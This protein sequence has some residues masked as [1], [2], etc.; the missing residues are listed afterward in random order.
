[1]FNIAQKIWRFKNIF[2]LRWEP[3]LLN[4]IKKQKKSSKELDDLLRI[5][6]KNF[7]QSKTEI[8]FVAGLFLIFALLSH[9]Q[10]II[11]AL[12]KNESIISTTLNYYPFKGSLFLQSIDAHYSNLISV[13][14]G[15]GA[16]L[17][18]LAFFIAQELTKEGGPYKGIILLRRS[19]FFTLLVAEILSFLLFIWG[20]VNIFAALPIIII[21]IFTIISL[22][23]TIKL[24]TN[25]VGMKK[26]EDELLSKIIIGGFLKVLDKEITKRIATNTLI[27]KIKQHDDIIELNPFSPI[28]KEL[29]LP[30]KTKTVGTIIDIRLRKLKKLI[31]LIG[32]KQVTDNSLIDQEVET[33]KKNEYMDRLCQ[34]TPMP[35]SHTDFYSGN[36]FWIKK[37]ILDN[38]ITKERIERMARDIFVI[39]KED[40]IETEARDELVKLKIRSIEAIKSLRNEELED[41]VA[42]YIKLVDNFYSMILLYGGGFSREQAEKERTNFIEK[43]KPMDWLSSDIREILEVSIKSNRF[44]MIKTVAYL[45]FIFMRKAVDNKDHLVFQEFLYFSQILY[46]RGYEMQKNG[47]LRTSALVLDRTWRYLKEFC[48]YYLEQKLD[49]GEDYPVEDFKDFSIYL[50]KIFQYLLKAAL[51][52]QDLNNFKKFLL[53]V[54]GLFKNLNN[55]YYR[56]NREKGQEVFDFIDSKRSEM[57]FGLSSWILY[58]Y[59]SN[60]ENTRIKE[61]FNEIKSVLPQDIV[62]FTDIFLNVHNFKVE[63]FWG[64]DHWESSLYEEG[65]VH[66]IQIIEKTERLYVIHALNLI[67]S[68][69]QKELDQIKLPHNRDMEFLADG[70]RDLMKTIKNI[71]ENPESWNDLLDQNAISKTDS[72]RELLKKAKEDQEEDDLEKKRSTGIDGNKIKDFKEKFIKNYKDSHPIKELIRKFGIYEDKIKFKYTGSVKK[73]GINTL[74]D[75]APFFGD[76][77]SWHVHYVGLDEAFGFGRSMAHG[78]NDYILQEII[79]SSKEIYKDEFYKKLNDIDPQQ[80]I[81]IATNHSMWNFFE[82]SGGQYVPKWRQDYPADSIDKM[83]SGAIKI[84]N[85]YI[86]IYEVYNS[87]AKRSDILIVNKSKIGKCIQYSPLDEN[88]NAEMLINEF[89]IGIK[90]FIDDSDIIKEFMQKQPPW[91]KE[92][93]G[94]V[95]KKNYLKERVLIHV[96]ERFEFKTSNDFE[97][98]VLRIDGNE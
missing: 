75:K 3:S 69:T 55:N 58:L 59:S 35:F 21:A 77:I 42:F 15:I 38:K 83:A 67:R 17:I 84:S 23:Q 54:N 46:S 74:F 20:S 19:R 76:D 43:L 68:K 95:N 12:F 25:N 45:P 89:L 56:K 60:K 96:F 49:H 61:F 44:E 70:T 85:F 78:E 66:N 81:V 91:L 98:L 82:R 72:L 16:V 34:I 10:T 51:D 79:K 92:I 28:H 50:L 22:Y 65:E 5:N 11:Q 32:S 94:D 88:D 31:S 1:M 86:P 39:K 40:D 41:L 80:V 62:K 63:D 71:E 27:E 24:I 7:W 13:H 37:D 64:W 57:I 2:G 97:G 52:N 73:L 26:G 4:L 14:T 9:F 30:I 87:D 48:D 90:D 6:T 36:L 29:Y 8:A 53:V 47:D 33:T 93:E 18:A